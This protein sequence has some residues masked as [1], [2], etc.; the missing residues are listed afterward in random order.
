[1]LVLFVNENDWVHSLFEKLDARRKKLSTSR[2]WAGHGLHVAFLVQNNQ[3]ALFDLFL[4]ISI[5]GGGVV[6][7]QTSSFCP[8]R[9]A[10]SLVPFLTRMSTTLKDFL[11]KWDLV[12]DLA[13]GLLLTKV[14]LR[15]SAE[16]G[17]DLGLI[18]RCCSRACFCDVLSRFFCWACWNFSLNFGFSLGGIQVAKCFLFT[19]STVE[20]S[21][22]L[23]FARFTNRIGLVL[24]AKRQLCHV[25]WPASFA[26]DLYTVCRGW[27]FSRGAPSKCDLPKAKRSGFQKNIPGGSIFIDDGSLGQIFDLLWPIQINLKQAGKRYTILLKGA[28]MLIVVFGHP[29]KASLCTSRRVLK[30]Q[31]IFD[32]TGECSLLSIHFDFLSKIIWECFSPSTKIVNLSVSFH[33][34]VVDGKQMMRSTPELSD[35]SF[36]VRMPHSLGQQLR[37]ATLSH[38]HKI[39]PSIAFCTDLSQSL[40]FQVKPWKIHMQASQFAVQP[41][42]HTVNDRKQ[43]VAML[44]DRLFGCSVQKKCTRSP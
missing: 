19:P 35:S 20:L 31:V 5:T 37:E 21:A 12:S 32:K 40:C 41:A 9:G 13:T 7:R 36:G 26:H 28:W 10:A 4:A 30:A 22:V 11:S 23:V 6:A 42:Q 1:M 39:L 34:S 24:V 33:C 29:P 38:L 15:R 18:R 17:Q 43:T 2:G 44:L 8:G 3:V 25:F 14:A 27:T 16:N